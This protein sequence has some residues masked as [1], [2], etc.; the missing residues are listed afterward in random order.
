MQ[1][2]ITPHLPTYVNLHYVDYSDDL[3][4]HTD[5]LEETLRQN[6]LDP[7]YEK[8]NDWW[9]DSDSTSSY[10]EDIQQALDKEDYEL[11]DDDKDDIRDWLHEN[12]TS[13]PTKELLGNT[14]KLTMFYSL[15]LEVDGYSEA[16][17]FSPSVRYSSEAQEAYKIR[18]KLGIQK[19][20][21]E[22]E[23]IDS[24]VANASYGGELRIYFS[25]SLEDALSAESDKDFK[26]IQFKGRYA[27]AVYHSN[28]SGDFEYM[29]IDRTFPFTRDNLF[30]SDADKYS[31]ESCFG[32]CGDWLDKTTSPVMSVE[33]LRRKAKIAKSKS[34]VIHAR[35]AEYKRVFK[36]GGC[37]AGDMDIN[38]HRDVTYSNDVPC[39][40]RCP[41][42]RTFWID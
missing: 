34:A 39:G 29:E 10:I 25:L 13:D 15:G 23:L 24:I 1:A 38:R 18:R 5:L 2:Q 17:F 42:C 9:I 33:P 4:G 26:Q 35:E 31:L 8:V 14:G 3:S 32:M 30:T 27:I 28:G 11:S 21:K 12:D 20:T 40:S 19:G 22:A 36:A 6:C 41:H 7:I 16:G 37:T